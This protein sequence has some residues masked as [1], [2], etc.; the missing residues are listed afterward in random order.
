MR[1]YGS[2][3]TIK[4]DVK[5]TDRKIEKKMADDLQSQYGALVSITDIMAYMK[6]GRTKAKA[7]MAG[8]KTFGTGTG[9]RYF[10]EE[11]VEAIMKE[12]NY[13]S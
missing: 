4:G 8:Y 3:L 13:A 10:Y 6:I 11:V 2:D 12:R 1:S 9:A 7:L 5:M